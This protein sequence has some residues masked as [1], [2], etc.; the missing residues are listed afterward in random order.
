MPFH[1]SPCPQNNKLSI[2]LAGMVDLAQS[3]P[4]RPVVPDN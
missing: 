4:A 2:A 1:L 3:L